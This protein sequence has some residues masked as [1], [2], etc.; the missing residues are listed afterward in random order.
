MA[1]LWSTM[2]RGRLTRRVMIVLLCWLAAGCRA[3]YASEAGMGTYPPGFQD[4]MSGYLPPPGFYFQQNLEFYSGSAG[5]VVGEGNIQVD[6]H[7]TLPVQYS[8]L[9][10]VTRNRLWDSYYA[11]AVIVP[12]AG[13][14]VTGYVATPLGNLHRSQTVTA[15]S[16]IE[17]IPMMLGWHNGRSN[18]KAWLVVYTPTGEYSTTNF[19]NSSLNRWAV[20]FD[21][22]YTF[23]DPRT[24]IEFDVA[25]GYT[26]NFENPETNY[27]SGQEFHMDYAAL[28]HL[29]SGVGV[30]MAGYAFAQTTPDSG[31][32]AKLG[33]FEG[34]TFALGPLLSYDMKLGSVPVGLTAKYYSEFG[35]SKRFDGHSYW[36]NISAAF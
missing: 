18:Q 34:R 28:R 24:G 27:L 12:M 17:F 25:P 4:R 29:P 31:S 9:N 7:L 6:L 10:G 5:R 23:F 26:I 21:Y 8:I 20:E 33:A 32:G 30:G 1:G 19:V 11:W 2:H 15:L 36:L 14:D 35:V 13:P 16:E 3:A 22:A